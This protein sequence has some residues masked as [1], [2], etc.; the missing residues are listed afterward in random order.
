MASGTQG[1]GH[2]TGNRHKGRIN[3]PDVKPNKQNSPIVNKKI[4]FLILSTAG[5]VATVF[6]QEPQ[7]LSIS[8]ETAIDRARTNSV[9]AEMAV[10]ELRTAYWGY[11]TYRAELL[12]ELSFA[13]T[14]PAYYRQFSALRSSGIQPVHVDPGFRDIH[15]AYIR[16]QQ[17]KMG[18]QD[19]T[20]AL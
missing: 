2:R 5:Y 15:A 16:M 1:Y 8:L 20:R 18:P 9:E 7:P 17:H 6:G 14:V 19:R 11:R 10:N 12:P 3:P 13:A 4:I